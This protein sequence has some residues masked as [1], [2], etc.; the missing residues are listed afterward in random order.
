MDSQNYPEM[1]LEQPLT[2]AP[3]PPTV[4]PAI[5]PPPAPERRER[6]GP[7]LLT[8]ATIVLLGSMIGGVIS[9]LI[10]YLGRPY[11]DQRL[12]PALAAAGLAGPTSTQPVAVALAT[13]PPPPAAGGGVTA[14]VSAAPALITPTP[15]RSP[16]INT[17]IISNTRHFTGNPAAPVTII[18]FSDFQ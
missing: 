14:T 10:V 18:E 7:S 9:G 5:V 17:F 4:I 2:A 15:D 13:N 1:E 6:P 12:G 8:L 3:P 16:E 11:L